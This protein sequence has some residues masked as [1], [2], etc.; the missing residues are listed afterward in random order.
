[1]KLAE[2]IASRVT[3]LSEVEVLCKQLADAAH[4]LDR[5]VIAG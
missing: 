3:E 4:E 1:M 5:L 2:R